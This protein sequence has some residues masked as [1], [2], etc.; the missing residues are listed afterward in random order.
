M[1]VQHEEQKQEIW[2]KKLHER[3]GALSVGVFGLA[4]LRETILVILLPSCSGSIIAKI[5]K[6]N[7]NHHFHVW[8]LAISSCRRIEN[9][10]F[11]A[12]LQ[13]L[14]K[15][16]PLFLVDKQTVLCVR[17]KQW[18]NAKKMNGCGLSL[19]RESWCLNFSIWRKIW[20]M[21]KCVRARAGT[22]L[23]KKNHKENYKSE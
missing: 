8:F 16:L 10:F 6:Q 5:C 4:F 9:I 18:E 13:Q 7:F 2:G 21:V 23:T 15:L 3:V 22:F 11:C 12:T 1:L 14:T 20:K 17:K 19:N